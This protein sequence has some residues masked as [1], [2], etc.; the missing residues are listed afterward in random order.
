MTRLIIGLT[1]SDRAAGYSSF[2]DGYRPGAWQGI[3]VIEVPDVPGLADEGW[4]EAVFKAT[5][6]PLEAVE[7][8][9]GAKAVWDALADLPAARSLSAGDTVTVGGVMYECAKSGWKKVVA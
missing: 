3:R 2:L 7:G 5:N 8:D 9:P 1:E 4:A 6:A